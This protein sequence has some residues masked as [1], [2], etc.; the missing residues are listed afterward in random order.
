MKKVVSVL[1]VLMFLFNIFPIYISAKE[2]LVRMNIMTDWSEGSFGVNVLKANNDFY[3]S[4]EDI[5]K[6]TGYKGNVENENIIFV[7]GE[8]YIKINADNNKL[9]VRNQKY[10]FSK[11]ITYKDKYYLPISYM[12]P[13]MNVNCYVKSGILFVERDALSF[14][15]VRKD[16]DFNKF[17]FNVNKVL[18]KDATWIVVNMSLFN[19]ILNFKDVLKM[20]D[21]D[22]SGDTYYDYETYLEAFKELAL[23]PTVESEEIFD[24]INDIAKYEKSAGKV[25]EIIFEN[26]NESEA[27]KDLWS[28]L[29]NRSVEDVNKETKE[30]FGKISIIKDAVEYANIIGNSTEDYYK[31]F[32]YVYNSNQD[33]HNKSVLRA[34]SKADNLFR[35]NAVSLG[36]ATVS[37]LEGI[38]ADDIVSSIWEL[39]AIGTEIILSNSDKFAQNALKSFGL[40]TALIDTILTYAWP[41]NKAAEGISKLSVYQ[42][43]QNEAISAYYEY[44]DNNVEAARLSA[45]LSLKAARKCYEIV[46]EL[47][48]CLGTEGIFKYTIKEID[49]LIISFNLTSASQKNDSL[50]SK[51]EKTKELKNILDQVK[52]EEAIEITENDITFMRTVLFAIG[53]DVE[54]DSTD[55]LSDETVAFSVFNMVDAPYNCNDTAD[56][57]PYNCYECNITVVETDDFD[58]ACESI[59]D[60]NIPKN[61]MDFL[62]K[63]GGYYILDNGYQ[64]PTNNGRGNYVQINIKNIESISG[65]IF[66]KYNW[67]AYDTAEAALNKTP[68]RVISLKAEFE[69]S[70]NIYPFRIKS[71]KFDYELLDE[72]NKTEFECYNKVLAIYAQAATQGLDSFYNQ[73]EYYADVINDWLIQAYYHYG[74]SISYA[75][76]DIDNNGTEELILLDN[77][78]IFDI[79][80]VK[81]RSL[82]NLFPEETFGYRWHINILNNHKILAHGSGG[83]DESSA[84]VYDFIDYKVTVNQAFF[85]D[86]RNPDVNEYS[87]FVENGYNEVSKDEY[88]EKVDMLLD[89]TNTVKLNS[90]TLFEPIE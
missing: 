28:I 74:A 84:V 7:L 70:I 82:I 60:R 71:I 83:A 67:C 79:Y 18:G 38:L 24:L 77:N 44:K 27:A 59:F 51:S 21:A 23:D 25:F 49:K 3:M 52:T 43:I 12:F 53:S 73:Q 14:W 20:V 13:W 46:D 90:I 86:Y 87:Y 66:V 19:S 65:N 72:K 56:Y 48:A 41:I 5:S 32:G 39:E 54:F 89:E 40:Y 35:K 36:E 75:L 78:E 33:E 58:V 22:F 80:T 1:F 9:T 4:V 45:L 34:A 47:Y 15:E 57:I 8:K 30:L 88:F 62:E 55:E 17:V 2:E 42:N 6:V 68:T 29:E 81:N 61:Q 69:N 37:M 11:V 10:D 63:Y 16:F 26:I 85:Y 64:I 50:E 76:Y 31:T